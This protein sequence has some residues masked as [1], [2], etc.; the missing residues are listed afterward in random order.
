MKT[1]E[2]MAFEWWADYSK[3]KDLNK[4]DTV[5]PT[6]GFVAGYAYA[7]DQILGINKIAESM[8]KDLLKHAVDVVLPI[9][10]G[11]KRDKIT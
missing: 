2:Q 6:V 10:L 8:V 3:E 5:D 4:W 9:D 11:G 7:M 1:P